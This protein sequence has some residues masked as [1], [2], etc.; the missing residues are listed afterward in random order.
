[1]RKLF[2]SPVGRSAEPLLA[3]TTE[4]FAA[5]GAEFLLVQYEDSDLVLPPG[6]T[7]LRDSGTKWQLARKHLHPDACAAYD[8]VFVWDDDIDV[9]DFD[10]AVFTAIMAGNGLDMA[11][12]SLRSPHGLSHRI[13]GQREITEDM[14]RERIAGRLTNF[15]EIMVPVFSREGWRLLHDVLDDGNL[16]GWGYDYLPIAPRGIVDSMHVVHTRPVQSYSD[17][18]EAEKVRLLSHYGLFAYPQIEMGWLFHGAR[19]QNA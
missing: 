15:V 16:S 6:V 19:T 1:M 17:S 11:Q 18:A 8:Y 14:R 9:A 10:P 12:P 2:F 3:K 7:S 4:C 5:A 13:T